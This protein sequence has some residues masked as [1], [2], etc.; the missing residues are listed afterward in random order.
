[1]S[2][3]YDYCGRT[4]GAR[5]AV[6]GNRVTGPP[7]VYKVGLPHGLSSPGRCLKWL[8]SDAVDDLCIRINSSMEETVQTHGQPA[9]HR[10]INTGSS[11]APRPPSWNPNQH[12]TQGVVN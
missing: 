1:M 3:P 10:R 2:R 6:V 8:S 5:V 4:C 11:T 12:T 9:V 7:V